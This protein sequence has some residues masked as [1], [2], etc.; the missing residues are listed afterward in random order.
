MKARNRQ[1]EKYYRSIRSWLPCSRK[2]K[3]K[4]L[5]QIR[6]NISAY[7]EEHPSAAFSDIQQRF[8]KPQQI[9]ATYVN[10]LETQELLRDLRVRKKIV[11]IVAACAT[12]IIVMW[13]ATV[14]TALIDNHY[15]KDGFM[16]V[17]TE[18]IN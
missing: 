2:L 6:S 14:I 1:L 9:A 11:R 5:S 13:G 10:E 18:A 15:T 7:V 8:G 16:I 3:K 17:Y 12:T 4:L